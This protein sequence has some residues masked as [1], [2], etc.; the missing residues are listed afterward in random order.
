LDILNG[1]DRKRRSDELTTRWCEGSGRGHDRQAT[2]NERSK[3]FGV[4]AIGCPSMASRTELR[5]AC[6]T[7]ALHHFL[8][9]FFFL[10]AFFLAGCLAVAFAAGLEAFFLVVFFLADFFFCCLP[11]KMSFQLLAYFSFV[12]TRR[13]VMADQRF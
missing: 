1:G 6:R 5:A 10:V 8:A 2:R 11:P 7:T 12:P 13:M 4:D 3:P 9:V